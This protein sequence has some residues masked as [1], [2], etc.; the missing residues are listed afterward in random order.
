MKNSFGSALT[1]TIFGESHGAAIGAVIDGIAPGIAIDDDYI[2]IRMAQRRPAGKISTKR[3]EA[4]EVDII[5]GVFNGRTTGTPLTIVIK[6]KDT[7]SSDYEAMRSVARPSH[8]DYTAYAKYHGFQDARGGGHFSGRVTAALVAGGSIVLAALQRAGIDITTHI[9]RCAGLA[10]TPFALDDPAALAAQAAAPNAFVLWHYTMQPDDTTPVTTVAHPAQQSDLARLH[11]DCLI[12]M[13]WNK[14]YRCTYARQLAFDQA[15]TLGEDLQFVLD[16]LALL[17]RCQPDFSYLVLESALTFYDCSRTGTLSTKYHANYCEIWP[18]HFAK[19]NAACTAAACPPQDMLPLHRAE[20]QV[21]AEGA[22]DI[23]RRD[24]DAM[25]ARRA[26][27]RTALQSP[28]LKSLLDTMR[29]EHCY[30]PYYLP[31]R[32][33]S[34]R[35]LWMLSEAA[36]TQSPLFGKLDWAGYYLL[37][38]RMKRG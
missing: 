17:G 11:L 5:S 13:P 8:A 19:L 35:L 26:K 1:V 22:A 27:A 23:L 33:N 30:S 38:G 4:D 9:A 31:C 18:K 3:R 2:R 14:L 32:W 12:A 37:L 25:P 16:Y 24:P 20:L 36:R 34:L 29:H 28:W 15:Y 21:L 10:D 7:K 6:N